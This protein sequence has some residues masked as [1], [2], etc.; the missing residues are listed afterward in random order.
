MR[1][2]EKEISLDLVKKQKTGVIHPFCFLDQAYIFDSST[3]S[4]F[5]IDQTSLKQDGSLNLPEEDIQEY[6]QEGY[7][8]S[9]LISAQPDKRCFKALCFM[10]TK[11]CNFHCAYCFEGPKKSLHQVLSTETAIE[12]LRWIGDLSPERRQIE[13]DFFGGEPLLVFDQVKEIIEQSDAL[14]KETGKK[15]LFSLTTNA[16]L[17]T[18]ERL[19]FLNHHNISLIVSM[20]GNQTTHDHFRQYANQA[21]TFSDVWPAIQRLLQT[22]DGGYY[23]RGTYTH[24]TLS[25]AEQVM[26]MYEQGIKKISFEPVVSSHPEIGIQTEDLPFLKQEY[27]KLAEWTVR[28]KKRDPAFSFYHFELD[29]ENGVCADK[30]MTSCGAGVEYLSLSPDGQVYPC[31]QFDDMPD[32][33]LG[34][35]HEKKMDTKKVEIFRKVTHLTN[36]T[37]CADCWAKYLCGGGCIA[38]NL[39]MKGSLE[40]PY[41]IACEIQKMRLEAALYVQGQLRST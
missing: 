23:I 18:P 2:K 7:F 27:E 19:A 1:P 40:K 39:I 33:C 41:A 25:F 11:Q 9:G 17:L 24:Q 8:Q 35:V 36:K 37:A 21:G 13:A 29:L 10:M 30:L 28:Q 34:N 38:N 4:L 3:H 15:Y 5:L 12:A 32:Y 31:H 22:R 26:W 6:I 20:D 14:S 16:S